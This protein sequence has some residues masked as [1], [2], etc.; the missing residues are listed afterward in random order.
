MRGLLYI[1]KGEIIMKKVFKYTLEDH[2]G[3][4]TVPVSSDVLS[5]KY[6]LGKIIA[7]VLVDPED[8]ETRQIE[9]VLAGTGYPITSDISSD[10]YMTTLMLHNGSLVIHVF[11]GVGILE[12]N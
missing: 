1:K 7:Y 9:Y 4:L 5:V 10:N 2:S 12:H 3:V 11:M 8:K 6:Q